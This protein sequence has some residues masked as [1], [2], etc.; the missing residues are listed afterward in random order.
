[1]PLVI[2]QSRVP[3]P[4]A[5]MMP[6]IRPPPPRSERTGTA[7]QSGSRPP[8]A[9][10]RRASG[11][12]GP[13]RTAMQLAGLG[14]ELEGERR[15]ERRDAVLALG[16]VDVGDQ[17]ADDGRPRSARRTR[18]RDPPRGRRHGG[19]RRRGARSP[20]CRRSASRPACRP[21]SRGS[22]RA[23]T[24]TYFACPGGVSAKW[25]PRSTPR[26]RHRDVRLAQVERAADR[27]FE[28]VEPVPLE[29]GS[30]GVVPVHR[31]D[32]E[33]SGN[34][35]RADLHGYDPMPRAERPG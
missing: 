9:Q 22:R 24:V 14:R 20:R 6:R 2:G 32:L 17:V 5:R 30:A 34:V 3:D 11:R 8:L 18:A 21:R 7:A 28:P 26:L 29:E 12:R 23:A 4:P 27:L 1:M 25:M 10:R 13:C 16:V 33:G 31:A 15:V 35:H 19:R